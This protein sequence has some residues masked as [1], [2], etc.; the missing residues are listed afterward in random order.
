MNERLVGSTVMCNILYLR[1]TQ[2]LGRHNSVTVENKACYHWQLIFNCS[3]FC[4]DLLQT[5]VRIEVKLTHCICTA[6]FN[7]A[8]HQ[9]KSYKE[10]MHLTHLGILEFFREH[11]YCKVSTHNQ[12][13]IFSIFLIR[14]NS[15]C[16]CNIQIH[17]ISPQEQIYCTS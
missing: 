6:I 13:F 10:C 15:M 11:Q 1:A 7:R 8:C 2:S 12:D 5:K 3:P 9:H 4:N 16:W 14:N 17:Q